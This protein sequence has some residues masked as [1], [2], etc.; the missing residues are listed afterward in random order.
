MTGGEREANAREI[1]RKRPKDRREIILRAAL[2]M[3]K[4]RGFDASGIDEIAEAAGIT[5]GAVY[6]HFENKQQILVEAFDRIAQRLRESVEQ[7]TTM[8]PGDALHHL[9]S[10][11]IDAAIADGPFVVV[12]FREQANL[13]DK[14][15]VAVRRRQR[16]QME[17]WVHVLTHVRPELSD[18][19]ARAAVHAAISVIHSAALYG[20]D[21]DPERLRGF[22]GNM[23][24][25]VLMSPVAGEESTVSDRLS[26]REMA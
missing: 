18:A 24:M 20:S 26:A 19:E 1:S 25:A 7:A 3:F 13:P 5:G 12:W 9:V 22:L 16:L 6:R 10:G 4:D 8:A 17:E 14:Y 23:A 15:R 2:Q 11:H 21:L